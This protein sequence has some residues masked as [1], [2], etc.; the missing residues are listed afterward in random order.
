MRNG[1]SFN[2]F[3]D[4]VAKK[5]TECEFIK[6]RINPRKGKS[7]NYSTMLL[8]DGTTSKAQDFYPTCKD[9]YRVMYYNVLDTVATSLKDRFNQSSFVAYKN[10]ESLLLKTIKT[11]DTSDEPE[12][13]KRIY[14]DEINI[15]QF[16]IE[17]DVLRVIFYEKKVDCFNSFLFEI[18]KLPR[19]QRLLF[20]CTVHMCKLLR[21][22]PVTTSTAERS[23]SI[24][25]IIKTWIHSK[26]IPVRFS[27]L[28]ILH[29]H[30]TL[31]DNLNLKNI[32]KI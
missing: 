24:T 2:S 17:G 6:D 5:S 22:N 9:R 19:E 13:I 3:C 26:M 12:Y 25:R 20:P 14:K 18:R 8:V 10:I 7:P 27:A 23:F 29:S 16:E 15:T 32:A 1:H 11:E 28:S 31:T 4:T 30:K 21:V